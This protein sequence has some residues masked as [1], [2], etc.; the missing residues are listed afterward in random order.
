MAQ[1][2]VLQYVGA[3][4]VPVF[5]QNPDG[6]WDWLSGVQYEP[7]TIVKYGTATYTSKKL[8]PST[9]GSPNTAPEYW[10]LT[11]DYNGAIV[12]LQNQVYALSQ[13]VE[14]IGKYNVIMI[15]D[16]YGEQNGGD[17][18]E[19]YWQLFASQLGLTENVDFF[20]YF[21]SGAGFGNGRFLAQLQSFQGDKDSVSDIFVCGGWNDS[22]KSQPYGTDQAFQAG[23]NNFASYAKSNFP[24]ARVTLSHISWGNPQETSSVYTQMPVSIARYNTI[25][26][27]WRILTGTEFIL[28]RY[29]CWDSTNTHPNQFGQYLLGRYLPNAFVNGSCQI[30]L[31]DEKTIVT[32][33]GNWTV[34]SALRA[35]YE[36]LHDSMAT[37]ALENDLQLASVAEDGQYIYT[38][39]STRYPIFG[40]DYNLVKGRLLYNS[41]CT[42]CRL[43]TKSD[44]KWH[45]GS[46][47]I[48]LQN[49][50]FSCAFYVVE[51]GIVVNHM[52]VR[53]IDIPAFQITIP[54]YNC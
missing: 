1:N 34:N 38:D 49:N 6:T 27:G 52:T 39:G 13:Q 41:V 43:Y 9:V 44:N 5:Y 11:G 46:V 53:Y 47:N 37:V 7:L 35:S 54:Y 18:T 25:Q 45:D 51:D 26:K 10:A 23:V 4:Y 20:P 2:N 24:Q 21:E 32:A 14:R 22:D 12:Q 40:S 28:H 42:S 50:L 15:G 33:G 3:R 8:V 19:W 17:I 36:S 31:Q 16:S 48:S 30:G 29:N